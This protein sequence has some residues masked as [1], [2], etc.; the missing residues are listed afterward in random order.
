MNMEKP[1]TKNTTLNFS[2]IPSYWAI[3]FQSDC[4]LAATCLRHR[5]AM[6]AP[7]DLRHHECVLPGARSGDTCHSFVEDRPVR[8]AYG[9]KGLLP[10]VTSE[11]GMALRQR[12]Y[13]IFGSTTQF[14]R[15]RNGRWPISPRQQAR[16]AALFRKA[17]FKKEP[18][19]DE[20]TEG[21]YFEREA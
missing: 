16:V 6:L 11:E 21:Y 1:V 14:Y 13:S 19:F 10:R 18:H 8:L 3:C 2:D 15:Y 20:Y 7:A 4:P 17:G 9:M 12:L 5:A